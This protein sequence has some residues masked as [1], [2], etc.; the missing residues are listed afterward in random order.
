MGLL[1]RNDP[2]YGG[3]SIEIQSFGPFLP[4]TRNFRGN[5]RLA[6]MDFE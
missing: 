3:H 4:Q 1:G 6:P 5:R 2:E